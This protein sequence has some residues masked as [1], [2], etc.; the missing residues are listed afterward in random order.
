[1]LIICYAS[2]RVARATGHARDS[3]D[4]DGHRGTSKPGA[5]RELRPVED[6]RREDSIDREKHDFQV[7]IV[8]EAR[9]CDDLVVELRS[10]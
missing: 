8:E 2:R 9:G 7:S 5:D 4:G 10:R 6:W 3:E 1:M